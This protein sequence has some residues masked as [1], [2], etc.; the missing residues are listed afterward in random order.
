MHCPFCAANDTRVVDTRLADSGGTIRRRRECLSCRERFTT[1]ERA[2][3]RMPQVTKSD[4][5]RETFIEDKLR[6]GIYRALEKRPVET[7][8]VE[9]IIQSVIRS[10]LGSGEREINSKRI[11]ELVMEQLGELDQVAYVRFASVYR[12]FQDVDAFSAEVNRIKN[13]PS[14]ATKRNQLSLL[15]ASGRDRKSR[16]RGGQGE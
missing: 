10:V 6:T 12:S 15:P 13:E 16:R 5:R 3:L 9:T 2:E 4:G 14:P 1:F 8:A 11:G 7:E